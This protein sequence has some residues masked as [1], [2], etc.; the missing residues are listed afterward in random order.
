M[1]RHV[2]IGV[3]KPGVSEEKILERINVMKAVTESVAEVK[4]AAVGRN[5]G[6]FNPQDAILLISDFENQEAFNAFILS[7]PHQQLGAVAGEVF[8]MDAS[9]AYQIQL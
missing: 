9:T 3:I 5:V 7:E 2:F 4:N 6:W 8:D 1:Y